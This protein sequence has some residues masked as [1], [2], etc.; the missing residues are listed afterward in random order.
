MYREILDRIQSYDTIVIHRHIQ[1]DLDAYGSQFGL[2]ELIR[3]NFEG[4][5]V[6]VVGD[7][8]DLDFL[9]SMDSI[10]DEVYEGALAIVVDVAG[11]DRVS[12]Q[13]FKLAKETMVID[14][15]RN[16]TDFAD[17]FHS[18]PDQIATSQILTDMAM[19]EKLSVSK[20]AATYLFAGLVT[21]SGRFLYPQTST[22]TF[23]AATFLS[24]RGARIQW[25][26][27]NLYVEDM[28][29]KKLKGYFINYFETTEHN[30][31]YMKN[32]RRLKDRF[33]VSTFTV[34][35]GMV[36]QM[37]NIS[38]IPIWAN[39]TEDDEGRILCEL[40]SKQE[41][42]VHV[43]KKF[44]GGGHALAC[45]CTVHSWEETDKVL[46]ELDRIAERL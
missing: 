44:G 36:N 21:D 16:G 8:S 24:E 25:V 14:H 13:R 27:E 32:D 34:S 10:P 41:S 30:V 46:E 45:G 9:G 37:A 43:A 15:H 3:D 20:E 23:K 39:F 31:A 22:L 6:Y 7:D 19:Q 1:P 2:R 33:D 12:D 4:K 42:I 29:F 17:H 18:D 28:N 11:S 40:R 5:T 35:R 38:T 26:Y